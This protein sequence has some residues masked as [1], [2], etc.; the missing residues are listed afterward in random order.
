MNRIR[1]LR[2]LREMSQISF[3]KLFNVDQTAVSNWEKEKNHIDIK[4]MEK[5]SDFFSVPMEFVYGKEFVVTRP[6]DE[7]YEDEI[8][9]FQNASEASKDYFMFKYGKGRFSS[10]SP[11]D[12]NSI[13]QSPALPPEGLSRVIIRHYDGSSSF[14][15][16]SPEQAKLI[17]SMIAAQ[18]KER[19]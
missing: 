7:W 4:T 12:E 5:I 11:E 17:E 15:D 3:A 18:K 14:A 6:M 13:V 1:C 16:F 10:D 19:Q 8:E 2:L 9:D